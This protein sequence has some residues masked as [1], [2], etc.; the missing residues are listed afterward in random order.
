MS[1]IRDNHEEKTSYQTSNEFFPEIDFGQDVVMCYGANDTLA[2]RVKQYRDRGYVVHFMTGIS[3]GGN[4]EFLNGKFD[5]LDHHDCGQRE[6]SGELVGHGSEDPYI[7]PSVAFSD[8][9][10]A[11]LKMAVDAGVEAIHVEEPEFWNRSGWSQ[12]FKREYELYYR[13]PWR[14]PLTDAD[15]AWRCAKLKAYLYKRTI[16]RVSA[17]VK[18]YA[19][20]KYGRVV[21]FYVPTHSLINYTQWKIISPES[22]LLDIPSVDGYITQI[23]TGTSR[24]RNAYEGVIRER[25]FETAYLEYGVMQELVR[26][27]DR[28]LWFLHD[29]IE[30]NPLYGWDDYEYNYFKTVTASLLH[31]RINDYEV[32]PWPQRFIRNT[33]PRDSDSGT[34]IPADYRTELVNIFQALGDMESCDYDEGLRVG[35]AMSDTS[36]YERTLPRTEKTALAAAGTAFKSGAVLSETQQTRDDFMN[37]LFTDPDREPQLESQYI[38]SAGFPQ[39]YGLALPLLKH[40]IPLRPVVI[41]N[42][43]RYSGCLDEL[44]VLVLSYEFIKPLSPA[45]DLAIADWVRRGGKLIYVGDD[46]D[47]YHGIREWWTAGKKKYSSPRQHLFELLSGEIS[48]GSTVK[49]GEGALTYYRMKPCRITYSH[50]AAEEYRAIFDSALRFSGIEPIHRDYLLQHRG[51]YIAAAVMDESVNSEPLVLNGLFADMYTPELDIITQ[52]TLKP[53]ENTLLFD[54]SKIPDDE[55]RVIGT[56]ARIFALDIHDCRAE[57]RARAAAGT[58][59]N[60][61]LR[62]P[63]AAK[64]AAVSGGKDRIRIDLRPDSLSRT[65]LLS[66]MGTSEDIVITIE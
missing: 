20:V 33:Y 32:C 57:V 18:E 30:D 3:W 56:G 51:P 26:G 1:Y 23:W 22:L 50:E 21:R 12:A 15:T 34:H 24:E 11:K 47:I 42:C 25:T 49:C 10:L 64:S 48:D 40:G 35:I 43:L 6:E 27:T 5:G 38:V 58:R 28:R 37:K 44:D 41:D 16:G 9:K 63:F 52:K 7:C 36:L 4:E 8:Y 31:P 62:L 19:L 66:F 17:A 45:V 2:D 13:E 46:S 29:P 60:I 59:T 14:D 65:V 55:P 61:R 53:D 54:L 39:F